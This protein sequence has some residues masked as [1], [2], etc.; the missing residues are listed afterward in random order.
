MGF[1]MSR[2]ITEG[3]ALTPA[4]FVAGLVN[5]SSGD[6]LTGDP[7]YLGAGNA[8]IA[9]DDQDFGD[10]L[11]L[12][13]TT[14]TQK[15]RAFATTP[16]RP[17]LYLRIRA[18]VKAVSGALP[19]VKVNAWVGSSG[20]VEIPGLTTTG[21][22]VTLTS[23]GDVVTVEAIVGT[24][25][26]GGVNLVWPTAA[27]SAR[28]GLDFTGPN[29]GVIRVEDVKIE[30]VSSFWLYETVSRV[31]VLDYGAVGDGVTD[32]LAAFVAADAAAGSNGELVV[33]AG[34]YY[35]SDH[36]TINVPVVFDG[37]MVMPT[38]KRLILR[39][40]FNLPGYINAF[41]GNEVEAFKRAFQALLN[42]AD[43]DS[44]DLGG[45]RIDLGGPV[46]LQAAE[47]SN[48]VFEVRRSIRN[49]QFN[50]T[51]GS[52]WNVTPVTSAASY[53]TSNSKTLTNVV[54]VA[55]IV[56]G[57]L[58]TGNGVGREVYV[59]SVDIPNQTVSLNMP[60]YGAAGNQTYTF[61]RFK[62]MLDFSNFTKLSKFVV[63]NVELMCNGKASGILLAPDGEVFQFRD[64]AMQR[65]K[66]RGITSHGEG[67]QDLHIDNC[68]F[69]SNEIG[70]ASTDRS[71]IAFNVNA[72]DAKIRGNRFQRFRHTGILRGNGHLLVGNHWFQG[73]ATANGP[74][75][76]GMVFTTPGTKSVLTGNY[77]DNSY[78]ELT[79]EHD[80][81]PNFDNNSY[82]FGGLTLTGNIFTANDVATNFSW[83]VVRPYG[84][85]HFIQGLSVQ[86]N[87][88]RTLNGNIA[89]I[90]AVD[91]TFAGLDN[92]RMRSVMFEGNTFHGIGQ[93]TYNPV[94][95]EFDQA[96]A[97]KTW[98]L[99][100]GGY[101]P[102]GGWARTVESVTT[103]GPITNAS[104]TAIYTMPYVTPNYG[105]NGNQVA[106]TWSENVKGRVQVT[107]RVDNPV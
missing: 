60:L 103:E 53:S 4:R 107:A 79:N 15:L 1:S 97:A 58:V 39:R 8:A 28:F 29:G 3:L 67:C 90:E 83:I 66:D 98:V 44:L 89:R 47:A 106:L 45:R 104:N 56:P 62:Y 27:R 49:G 25:D 42:N 85:G 46:D 96:T 87:C 81:D 20:T 68:Q 16:I 63:E 48:T 82:S 84:S 35:V 17:G 70:A 99:N 37:R 86:G 105:A 6:G 38:D 12:I 10:C 73:D 26:R 41:S 31:N 52:A 61:T 21:P 94:T 101:L 91:T 75:L 54:N 102:F 19:T 18:R 34:N 95:L 2:E 77:V 7:S 32:N 69:N 88:F 30:D 14:S 78:I 50:A 55:N 64:S 5:W 24:G 11:E 40:N 72:N 33:P 74:R 43:H 80:A 93:P 36:L 23:Y 100:V 13:K 51:D 22:A 9:P 57:S 59:K 71:T 76:A 92:G 65:P